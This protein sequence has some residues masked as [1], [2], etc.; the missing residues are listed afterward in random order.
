MRTYGRTIQIILARLDYLERL[1]GSE[2]PVERTTQLR[3]ASEI[4]FDITKAVSAEI[5]ND[6]DDIEDAINKLSI[7]DKDMPRMKHELIQLKRKIPLNY[8]ITTQDRE[9]I[10]A[11]INKILGVNRSDRP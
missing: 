7:I 10:L 8:Q 3:V 2:V 9:K 11:E 5:R 6:F 4:P 1:V